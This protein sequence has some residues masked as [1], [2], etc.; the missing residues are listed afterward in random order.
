M[1]WLNRRVRGF[2]NH[3]APLPLESRTFD[4]LSPDQ[5]KAQ[6]PAS[7][8]DLTAD[9]IFKAVYEANTKHPSATEST[10][11][12][13]E[14]AKTADKRSPSVLNLCE[15]T[16]HWTVQENI[17]PRSLYPGSEVHDHTV[18]IVDGLDKGDGMR[19]FGISIQP[20]PGSHPTNVVGIEYNRQS[21]SRHT[22]RPTLIAGLSDAE[23]D[24]FW[25][26]V[27]D[28]HGPAR[29]V[30]TQDNQS[31][32]DYRSLGHSV[33]IATE[34]LIKS[35]H[36]SPKPPSVESNGA[37]LEDATETR[38]A[39]EEPELPSVTSSSMPNYG[40]MNM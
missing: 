6:Y 19:I 31:R 28:G 12:S 32:D 4:I 39:Q 21:V 38:V 7:E 3:V 16:Y 22:T 9:G 40:T 2:V 1:D 11:D 36:R 33:I 26:R 14:P 10:P 18:E 13:S 5:W 30:D 37:M 8:Q 25:N 29:M 23:R 35:D 15:R 27:V 34:A 20:E 17:P 24:N